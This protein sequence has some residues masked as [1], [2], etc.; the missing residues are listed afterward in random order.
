M[1]DTFF[2]DNDLKIDG[3]KK[4]TGTQLNPLVLKKNAADSHSEYTIID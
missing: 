1:L 4:Q 3:F 2:C